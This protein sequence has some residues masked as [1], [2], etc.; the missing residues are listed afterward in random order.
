M[1]NMSDSEIAGTFLWREL[2]KLPKRATLMYSN[3]INQLPLN[4]EVMHTLLNIHVCVYVCVC[5]CVCLCVVIYRIPST[6]YH[7]CEIN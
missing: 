7:T 1:N 2:Q 3:A 5:V 6:P 4:I